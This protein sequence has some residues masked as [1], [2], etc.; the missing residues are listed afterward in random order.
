MGA[1]RTQIEDKVIALLAPLR[2]DQ[3]GGYVKQ[4]RPYTELGE[5]SKEEILRVLGGAANLPGL[6]VGTGSERWHGVSTGLR[7]GYN[8]LEVEILCCSG[9]MRSRGARARGGG[10][11]DG[12]PGIYQMLEDVEE[13]LRAAKVDVPGAGRLHVQGADLL[14][15]DKDICAWRKRF[16]LSVG[17]QGE[18]GLESGDFKEIRAGLGAP[19][20]LQ[21]LATGAGDALATAF[22]VVTLTDAAGLF[23]NAFVGQRIVIAGA[24]HD[25]NNGTFTVTAVPH[26][27][28][29]QYQNDNA[30]AEAT[31]GGTWTIVPQPY[32]SVDVTLQ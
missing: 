16:D 25:E 22:G 14:L 31:F 11:A 23:V 7:R 28:Q 18:I 20:A 3:T 17:S 10:P 1:P 5:W 6:L 29:I 15:H 4:I 26:A 9:S 19:T 21:A 12:D 24:A 13:T 27:N 8:K 32:V 30:V 2:K